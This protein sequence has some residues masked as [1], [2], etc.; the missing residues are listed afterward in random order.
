MPNNSDIML[1][2]VTFSN[3]LILLLKVRLVVSFNTGKIWCPFFIIILPHTKHSRSIASTWKSIDV[4]FIFLKKKRKDSENKIPLSF[5]KNKSPT[6]NTYI[7]F[8]YI[9][10]LSGAILLYYTNLDRLLRYK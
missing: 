4:I 9:F 1:L 10:L 6:S 8:R 7:L 3:K 2:D 5:F